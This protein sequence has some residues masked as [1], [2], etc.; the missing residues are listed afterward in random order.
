MAK[1]KAIAAVGF[2]LVGGALLLISCAGLLYMLYAVPVYMKHRTAEKVA[3]PRVDAMFAAMEGGTLSH[4]YETYASKE[5]RYAVPVEE[6]RALAN[7][8]SSR[9]GD[10]ESKSLSSFSVREFNGQAEVD[11]TYRATFEKGGG[12]IRAWL[13]EQEGDWK[14]LA[15]WVNAPVLGEEFATTKC[16]LCGRL[17]AVNGELC[18]R[19]DW[20]IARSAQVGR[21]SNPGDRAAAELP[22]ALEPAAGPDSDGTSTPPAK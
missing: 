14:F 5:L 6:Y 18:P 3:S 2:A 7:A 16:T 19:C 8:I 13:R 11:V 4:A 1:A 20:E 10:L 15:F 17:D 22:H 9:L 21:L 12:T